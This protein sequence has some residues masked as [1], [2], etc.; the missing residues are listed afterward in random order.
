MPSKNKVGVLPCSDLYLFATVF[1]VPKIVRMAT[2]CLF[3]F[4]DTIVHKIIGRKIPS[5]MLKGVILMAA[6]SAFSSENTSAACLGP[7][8]GNTGPLR[9]LVTQLQNKCSIA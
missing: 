4:L 7:L 9:K 8:R 1:N 2:S 5:N 6:A 3:V